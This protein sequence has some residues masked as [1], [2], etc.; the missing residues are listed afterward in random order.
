M[1][2]Q[3]DPSQPRASRFSSDLASN[4]SSAARPRSGVFDAANWRHRRALDESEPLE[5]DPEL[6]DLRRHVLYFR[7]RND[8]KFRGAEVLRRFARAV[9]ESVARPSPH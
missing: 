4:A 5:G 1:A 9:A 7:G 6:E 8:A 2:R 3:R